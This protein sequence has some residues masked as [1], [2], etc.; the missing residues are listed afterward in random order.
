MARAA[1]FFRG[2]RGPLTPLRLPGTTVGVRPSSSMAFFPRVFRGAASNEAATATPAKELRTHTIVVAAHDSPHKRQADVVCKGANDEVPINAAIDSLI[3]GGSVFFRSGTYQLSNHLLVNRDWVTLE[4]EAAPH[5]SGYI[6]PYPTHDPV[7]A[8]GG[9]LFVQNTSGSDGIRV[10]T[11]NY[12]TADA[13]HKGL[14]FKNLYL[15][16]KT[17]NANGLYDIGGGSDVSIVSNCSFQGWNNAVYVSWDGGKIIGNSIQDNAGVGIYSERSF[18]FIHNNICFDNGGS[19][20]WSCGTGDIVSNNVIGDLSAGDGIYLTGTNIICNG[21]H[22]EGIPA[23]SGIAADCG[24]NNFNGGI[25]KN[26]TITGNLIILTGDVTP[27]QTPNTTG[28]GIALGMEGGSA[29]HGCLVTGNN[30]IN[31]APTAGYAIIVRNGGVNGLVTA[32]NTAAWNG[33]NRVSPGAY[34]TS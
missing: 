33:A 3:N 13:R 8:P 6:G 17:Y 25:P 18:C 12:R 2:G 11:S 15:Y 20:V 14:A 7:G 34:A 30:V 29:V 5:W 22:V 24:G 27:N 9:A 32:N 19:G 10:G 31:S 23:G 16:G 1:V 26:L 4:A 21:N 28:D